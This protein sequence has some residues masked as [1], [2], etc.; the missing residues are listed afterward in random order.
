MEEQKL[1][2]KKRK[3]EDE[4]AAA[5]AEPEETKKEGLYSVTVED[6]LTRYLRVRAT[7][8]EEAEERARKSLEDDDLPGY[9]YIFDPNGEDNGEKEEVHESGDR[10]FKITDSSFDRGVDEA[11]DEAQDEF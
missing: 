8:A 1:E 11:E 2:E 5:A 6:V 4:T 7:S 10:N 3:R 9:S